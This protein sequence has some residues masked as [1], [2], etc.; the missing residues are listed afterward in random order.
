MEVQIATDKTIEG[1]CNDED[2][3][4]EDEDDEEDHE[5]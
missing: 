3:E 1:G 2:S 5:L 4:S